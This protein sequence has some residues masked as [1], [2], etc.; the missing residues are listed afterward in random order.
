MLNAATAELGDGSPSLSGNQ[1]REYSVW[2]QLI[3][4]DPSQNSNSQTNSQNSNS[5]NSNS[6]NLL[7][8]TTIKDQLDEDEDEDEDGDAT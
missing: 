8:T 2:I 6:Q 7:P 3:S 4:T 5:Q 1:W